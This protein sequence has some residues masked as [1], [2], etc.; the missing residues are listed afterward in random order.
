MTLYGLLENVINK[1]KNNKSDTDEKIQQLEE[2]LNNLGSSTLQAVYPV[3]SIYINVNNI[4]PSDIFGFGT[5]TQIKDTFLLAAGST[6]ATGATGGEATHTLTS[7][8][9]PA[10]YHG[11]T[12]DLVPDATAF[13]TYYYQ[14]IRHLDSTST[15]RRLLARG[16]DL[17]ALTADPAATDYASARDVNTS[18][19][20][21]TTGGGAAHNNMPPY[22]AVSVWKR[23]S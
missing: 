1:I 19:K 20:T 12:D 15:A 17:Y 3:G 8:E 9:M 11:P 4:N 2:Q 21:G 16:N 22:L 5:W 10:H 13:N 7:N 14:M 6:Y 23:V 18:S